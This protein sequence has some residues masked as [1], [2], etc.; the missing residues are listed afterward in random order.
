MEKEEAFELLGI[1]K[2][3]QAGYTGSRVKI[4]SDEKIIKNYYKTEAW[5][6]VISPKGYANEGKWHGSAVMSILID[7]CP[8]ADFIAFPMDMKGTVKKYESKCVDYI[9][10]NNV[11]L[12]TTSSVGSS[13]SATKEKA[14]QDCIDKGCTFFAA[15]GNEGQNGML[16]E[17]KSDKYL[18]IGALEPNTK[19]KWA[20]YSSVGEEL[21]YVSVG[22]YGFG[23][24]Y[25]TPTFCAMC[26]LVQDFFI[27]KTGRAL[28]RLE[29]IDF[30]ND[31]LIDVEEEGF[32]TKTGHGLFILPEPSEINIAKYI[33]KYG[34]GT[35]Y[36]GFP[37]VRSDVTMRGIDKLHP[38]MQMACNKFLEECERQGLDVCITETL[39]TQTEQEALYAKGRTEPGKIVTNCRG[40][41]SPHCWGVAFDFCRNVKGKEYDNS[42]GFFEKVGKIAKTIFDNTEYDLFWGGDFKTFV[43]R[44]HIEMIKY[45]PNN[46]TKW[47][48]DTYGTPEEFMKTWESEVE[49]VRYRTVEEM[50]EYYRK[51]IQ[52]LIDRG[53]IAGR[54]GETGLDLSDDMCRMAIYA[55]KIFEGGNK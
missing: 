47:L 36:T 35:V 38:K 3:H 2:F 42:D 17:G 1:N 10:E 24:S 32:D 13:C 14:M 51:D 53:I 21:D 18:A 31:N 50:P 8:D 48:I 20:S 9:L 5:Q 46:S 37:Q 28:K 44:P 4:M 25:T 12:F 49:E 34:T 45:L 16:G 41:Q 6:K 11:H 22:F 52:E 30:I 23:T 7:I 55:K 15:A 33:P 54:G 19:L 27:H 26:G 39:R 43:D 29:L 40:Y